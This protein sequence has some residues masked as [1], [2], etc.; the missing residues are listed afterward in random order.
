M[1]S[2]QM[3]RACRSIYAMGVA[4]GGCFLYQLTY[5]EEGEEAR[6]KQ[7]DDKKFRLP[8][9]TVVYFVLIPRSSVRQPAV[10]T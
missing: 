4:L 1:F 9:S 10:C 7:A 5:R 2:F 6:T 8:G 3:H